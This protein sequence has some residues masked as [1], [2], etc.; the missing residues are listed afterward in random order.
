MHSI[1]DTMTCSTNPRWIL[2]V[3]GSITPGRAG[4]VQES[5]CTQ[6]H[7]HLRRSLWK[8]PVLSA[9]CR[10]HWTERKKWPEKVGVHFENSRGVANDPTESHEYSQNN[11][12]KGA[13]FWISWSIQSPIRRGL[14]KNNPF[15]T[16]FLFN[17]PIRSPHI[18]VFRSCLRYQKHMKTPSEF[19]GSNV[20]SSESTFPGICFFPHRR[21]NMRQWRQR[22][23]NLVVV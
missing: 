2:E 7:W 22:K 21:T 23:R 8:G 11:S 13:S 3:I 15:Y 9:V 16:F 5:Q 12:A 20:K 1:L 19:S 17:N 4:G 10:V 18:W 14:W 6:V